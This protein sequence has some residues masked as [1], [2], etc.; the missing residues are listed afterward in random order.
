M[1]TVK[2][3]K[4]YYIYSRPKESGDKFRLGVDNY[5]GYSNLER[6]KEFLNYLKLNHPESEYKIVEFVTVEKFLDL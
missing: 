6:A 5:L 2:T 1:G 3:S 4:E